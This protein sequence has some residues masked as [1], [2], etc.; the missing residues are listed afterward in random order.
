MLFRFGC[1]LSVGR[2]YWRAMWPCF[3]SETTFLRDAMETEG[4]GGAQNCFLFSVRMGVCGQKAVRFGGSFRSRFC[5]PVLASRHLPGL[6]ASVDGFVPCALCHT[7]PVRKDPYVRKTAAVCVAKLYDINAEL[8]EDQGFLQI[9]RDLICD[10]N[11]TVGATCTRGLLCSA[12]V[13]GSC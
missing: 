5:G 11:P 10:P 2:C 3:P 6:R 4:G 7:I 8:V 12:V 9:L 13:L 1:Y